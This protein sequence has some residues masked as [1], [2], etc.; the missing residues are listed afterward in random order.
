MATATAARA[1]TSAASASAAA[2]LAAASRRRRR[3]RWRRAGGEGPQREAETP[4]QEGRTPLPRDPTRC[5]VRRPSRPR[6][7][8]AIAEAACSSLRFSARCIME[9]YRSLPPGTV[10]TRGSLRA[11]LLGTVP[12]SVR[13]SSFCSWLSS[14]AASPSAASLAMV[15]RRVQQRQSRSRRASGCRRWRHLNAAAFTAA[16]PCALARLLRTAAAMVERAAVS[17]AGEAG[18]AAAPSFSPKWAKDIS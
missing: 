16:H 8:A 18:R 9:R 17:V 15:A 1:S 5:T 7:A 2:E 11:S 13:A 4:Q 3:Q 14:G 6:R 12:S 10:G